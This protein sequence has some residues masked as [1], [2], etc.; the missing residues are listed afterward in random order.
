MLAA[1]TEV[2]HNRHTNGWF[3][4]PNRLKTSSE[5]RGARWVY[6]TYAWSLSWLVPSPVQSLAQYLSH[7]HQLLERFKLEEFTFCDQL[8]RITLLEKTD[9]RTIYPGDGE[10]IQ[11]D[12]P[13]N[14]TCCYSRYWESLQ[15]SYLEKNSWKLVQSF[16]INYPLTV[17]DRFYQVAPCP[18][19]RNICP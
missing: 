4:I 19:K 13:Q 17:L 9:K 6:N 1:C 8:L 14:T 7:L 16:N 3:Q 10:G 2:T 12:P 5:D 18:L 15:H 11:T